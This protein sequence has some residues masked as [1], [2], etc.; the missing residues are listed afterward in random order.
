MFLSSSSF[1]LQ[2]IFNSLVSRYNFL[3]QL[4]FWIFWTKLTKLI[5]QSYKTKLHELEPKKHD[6]SNYHTDY[7]PQSQ[8]CAIREFL[9][10]FKQKSSF[11]V[12][13][14]QNLI[15]QL[16]HNDLNLITL[17]YISVFFS[18]VKLSNLNHCAQVK[19]LTFFNKK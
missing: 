15:R 4:V 17:L 7:L 14:S 2:F 3:T 5:H 8:A 10:G 19:I 18:K 9:F 13:K 11:F 1:H 16:E 6:Y 12:E